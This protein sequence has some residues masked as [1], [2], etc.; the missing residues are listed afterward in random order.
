MAKQLDQQPG[1]THDEI[2][3]RAYELFEKSG[4]IPGRDV[5][6]WLTAEQQLKTDHRA[7]AQVRPRQEVRASTNGLAK[8]APRQPLGQ[9]AKVGQYA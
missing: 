7:T 9:R 3:R 1:P 4:R 6:N 8:T 2:A 5:E